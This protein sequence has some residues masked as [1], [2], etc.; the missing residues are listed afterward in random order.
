MLDFSSKSGAIPAEKSDAFE[1]VSQ[2]AKVPNGSTTPL[3]RIY[4]AVGDRGSAGVPKGSAI[5]PVQL[6]QLVD[7]SVITGA[8]RATIAK[9]HAVLAVLGHVEK[10]EKQRAPV[11]STL[12]ANVAL[13]AIGNRP[14]A[15]VVKATRAHAALTEKP[16]YLIAN[17]VQDEGQERASVST[18]FERMYTANADVLTT[19]GDEAVT[20]SNHVVVQEVIGA[21]GI[22]IGND[23]GMVHDQPIHD[24]QVLNQHQ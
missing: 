22:K 4:E 1:S 17:V 10:A 13:N 21:S 14:T 19:D 6:Q 16:A 11:R 15:G 20:S 7:S 12:E 24:L 18:G 5:E 9:N 23:P 8:D 3:A 2:G